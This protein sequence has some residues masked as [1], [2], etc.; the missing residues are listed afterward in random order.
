M[1]WSRDMDAA[2]RGKTVT[3]TETD[4][5]G[6]ARERQEFRRDHV[7]LATK[8]GKVTRSY[9]ILDEQRWC[10]LANGE[11]PVAWMPWP[12][13]PGVRSE[14]HFEELPIIEDCGGGE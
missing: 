7:I 10:M 3:I 5:D 2:P 1:S 14:P 6:K 9:W 13:H 8:C 11:A 4:K 12:D